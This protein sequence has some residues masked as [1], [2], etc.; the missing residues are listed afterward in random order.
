MS[1]FACLRLSRFCKSG[2]GGIIF[3]AFFG[4]KKKANLSSC[5]LGILSRMSSSSAARYL[6]R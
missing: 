6:T 3:G 5:M 2:K 4:K 1:Q